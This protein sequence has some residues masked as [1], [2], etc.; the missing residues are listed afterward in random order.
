[1][2]ISEFFRSDEYDDDETDY[3]EESMTGRPIAWLISY[4]G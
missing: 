3:D 4:P 2:K 1:M